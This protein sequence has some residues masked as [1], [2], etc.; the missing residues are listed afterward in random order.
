M[1]GG[2]RLRGQSPSSLRGWDSVRQ[3]YVADTVS[4]KSPCMGQS[5]SSLRRWDSLRGDSETVSMDGTVSV[6]FPWMGQSP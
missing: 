3:V 4:V 6:K 5:P 1:D 2:D